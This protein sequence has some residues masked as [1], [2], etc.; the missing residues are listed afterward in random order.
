M[1]HNNKT[2]LIYFNNSYLEDYFIEI[3]KTLYSV[4]GDRIYLSASY[5]IK[6][7]DIKYEI[8]NPQELIH[9]KNYLI[10]TTAE[11]LKFANKNSK[12][13]TS[14]HHAGYGENIFVVNTNVLRYADYLICSLYSPPKEYYQNYENLLFEQKCTPLKII[15]IGY[16]KLDKCIDYCQ[17]G[18]KDAIIV[19]LT[20][21]IDNDFKLDDLLMNLLNLLIIQT[22]KNIIFRPF[23]DN[24]NHPII[25]NIC[26]YF[27]YNDRFI[28]SEGSY[29]EHFKKSDLMIFIG[30]ENATTAY[31]FAYSTLKGVIFINPMISEDYFEI[32]IGIVVK[33]LNNLDKFI[34]KIKNKEL[35][36]KIKN[37]RQNN[38]INISNSLQCLVKNIKNIFDEEVFEYNLSRKSWKFDIIESIKKLHQMTINSRNA[39]N[40]DLNSYILYDYISL[41]IRKLS[42]KEYSIFIGYVI[43]ILENDYNFFSKRLIVKILFLISSIEYKYF[44]KNHLKSIQILCNSCSKNN[45]IISNEITE[46]I[47]HINT[48]LGFYNN[49]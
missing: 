37:S 12:L 48:R 26:E 21:I 27:S 38:V 17:K 49:E 22:K 33:D 25:K 14:Y 43:Y 32:D 39:S 47:F 34:L 36:E 31:T 13:I 35:E 44:N 7:Y 46:T 11:L 3:Y 30:R 20:D 23:P 42:D 41:Y 19:A 16:P 15:P 9:K 28:L 40:V 24:I 1:I 8:L 2:L 4:F 5:E 6:S 18:E 10:W 29:L 45:Q